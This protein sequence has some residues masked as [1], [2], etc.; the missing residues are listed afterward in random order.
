ALLVAADPPKTSPPP[1]AP[2]AT[3]TT[4]AAPEPVQRPDETH[5]K[6]VVQLTFG[7][8]NAEAYFDQTGKELIMQSRTGKGDGPGEHCDAIYRMGADGKNRRMISPDAKAGGGRTT[9]S[10][11]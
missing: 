7:G 1:S 5:L 3:T 2:P 11:I 9:C 8:E 6:N 10:F 4:P